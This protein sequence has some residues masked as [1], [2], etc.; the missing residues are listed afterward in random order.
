MIAY[1]LQGMYLKE[2]DPA[3]AM[4]LFGVL[5]VLIAILVVVNISKNGIGST[6]MRSSASKTTRTH[7]SRWA[8][9]KAASAYGLDA[10]QTSFLERIFRKAQVT[11]PETTLSNSELLD[12][13]F[14]RAFRDIESSAETEAASE[15]EKAVLF[16]IRTSIDSVQGSSS[17][18]LSTRKLPDGMAAVLTGVKGETYP[19]RIISAKGEKLLIETPKNTVGTAI[20]FSRGT[21]LALSFYTKTSQGYR[22][23]T[24]AQGTEMTPK[25]PA[26]ELSHSDRVA[27]LPNRRHRR[28][29]ARISCY[30]SS[31]QVIQR[32]QG[33]KVIKETIVGR[34]TIDGHDRRRIRRRLRDKKRGCDTDGRIRQG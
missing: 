31:V 27:P 23:E 28:K 17:R 26:L 11:D 18:V 5:G 32:N 3:T 29:E 1:Q 9:K 13:H 4:V 33:R 12:R 20:K 2:S 8:L 24:K 7:F 22:F 10:A 14:K 15:E 25:G 21:K 19:T 34:T 6:G 16:S 30:F